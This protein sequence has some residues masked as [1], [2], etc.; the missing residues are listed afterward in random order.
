L[1]KRIWVF[2]SAVRR[3][4][5]AAASGWKWQ[6]RLSDGTVIDSASTFETLDECIADARRDGFPQRPGLI[7]PAGGTVTA[8]GVYTIEIIEPE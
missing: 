1:G 3:H 8:A 7:D 4:D 5:D 2:E 6:A